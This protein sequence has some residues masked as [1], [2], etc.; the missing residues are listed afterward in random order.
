M[1]TWYNLLFKQEVN[2][3]SSNE[4]REYKKNF[5]DAF[6]S[7]VKELINVK[8]V[9]IVGDFN[10]AHSDIDIHDP[11]VH[12]TRLIAEIQEYIWVSSR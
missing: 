7:L 9:V 12:S 10:I 2:G 4:R 8:P 1:Y 11:I 3:Q 6:Y 5:Q